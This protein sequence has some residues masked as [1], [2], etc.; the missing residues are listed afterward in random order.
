ME[1]T[2]ARWLKRPTRLLLLSGLAMLL[3]TSSV[4]SAE[5]TAIPAT[6]TVQP[7]ALPKPSDLAKLE[8]YPSKLTL[9]GGDDAGQLII[10]GT[11][12]NG[13][14]VDLT[15]DVTYEAS[16]AKIVR[17]T[18]TGRVVPTGDGAT[19]VVAKY[20]D[21]SIALPVS[22]SAVNE[23]LPINFTNQIVP[24]FTKL[25]CNG[26]GC[27][28]K[29]AGQNGFRLGLLGFDPDLDYATLVKEARGRR[30]FPA[31]PDSSLFLLKATA[32]MPHG[33]GKKMEPD[34]DEY[35]LVRR[36]IAAGMPYGSP[37]DPTVTHISVYPEHRVLSRQSRQQFAVYAHYTDGSIEDITRR[38]QYDSNDTEIA[39]VDTHAL[40]RT[41]SMSGEAAIMARYQGHVAVFRATVPL[42][43]KTPEWQFPEQ[44]VVDKHTS[45]Q[46]RE[47]G[48][49]PS[50]R[51]NDETFIRRLYLDLTGTLP[52]PTQVKQFVA[53][54]NPAKRDV[55]VDQLLDSPEYAYYFANKWADILRVKRNGDATRMTGTFGFHDWIRQAMAEDMPYDRFVRSILGATGDE[56]KNPPTVWYKELQQPEQFVD[57]TAQVFLGQRLGCANCH[58]HPY[59]KWSQDDYWGLAAFFGR[60]G[61]KNVPMNGALPGAP[62]QMQVVFSRSSGSVNNKRTGQPAKFKPLD[63]PVVDVAGEDDP[64]QALLDWMV[65]P[66]NPFFARAVANRYWAHFFGRGIVDPIDDMRVTNPPSN[67]ALLDALADTLTSNQ[68]SLKS[69]V[70]AIVKSR[71]YQLSAIPNEF[72]KHDKQAYARYYPK[73][74]SAEVLLDAVGQVTGSPT[75]FGGLPSDKFAPQRAIMLPDEN[76]STYFLE[77]FGRPSRISACECERVSEA[78]LA[79]ALHLLNSDEVQSKLSRGG[80]RADLLAK[81]ARP[82][83]EKLE[84]LWMWAFSRKPTKADLDAA[85]AHI[86]KHG[87]NKKTA[88]ENIVWALINTKEFVFNQ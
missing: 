24:I 86:Q 82:D 15:G 19:Q 35:K 31:A 59:E 77:V 10:T 83:A 63:G 38:A 9:K 76:F 67:P 4:R 32:K 78:N 44:T 54:A 16:D 71:T 48:L 79:Q 52:T 30:L 5:T 8:I 62:Q 25:S 6:P 58:H 21:K 40:V 26:G 22:V 23:N 80:S 64:R 33:G 81:D 46:W 14:L 57:D 28:G 70:K 34:S 27:H 51:A 12:A 66:K 47:L 42:G 56:V 68:Y 45:K 18:T 36:W 11:L 50:E 65:Q 29:I 3:G 84:E 20:G 75:A 1:R 37:S 43:E 53:D 85:L 55:L 72:N 60:V 49:V 73:R 13:R 61:R 41:L 88:Y 74:M 39:T 2:F 69:L 87:A 7:A 17:I